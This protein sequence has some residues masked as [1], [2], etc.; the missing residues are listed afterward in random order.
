MASIDISY[1][2]NFP[3]TIEDIVLVFDNSGLQRPTNDRERIKK[4]FANSNLVVSAWKN[5]ELVAIARAVTDFA[6]CCYL[7][8]LAVKKEFQ[9]MG[10]GKELLRMIRRQAGENTTLL[11]LSAPGAMDYYPRIGM[12]KIENGFLIKRVK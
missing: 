6:Y 11:L 3:L 1:R 4:M 5:E 7:S 12:E 10:I 8:D 2:V 9:K